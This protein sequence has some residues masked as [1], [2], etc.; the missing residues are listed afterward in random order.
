MAK[1]ER[2]DL[3]IDELILP[4]RTELLQLSPAR[5]IRV[6]RLIWDGPDFHDLDLELLSWKVGPNEQLV[7]AVSFSVIAEHDRAALCESE[8]C[9]PGM[10]MTFQ[11][12]N[13]SD[14][15]RRCAFRVE[16]VE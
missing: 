11:V 6:T 7:H 3:Q 14:Q 5:A 15:A 13:H 9:H 1:T 8:T 10:R 16:G 4:D 2:P 12:R